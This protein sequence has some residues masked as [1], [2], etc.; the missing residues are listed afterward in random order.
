MDDEIKKPSFLVYYDNEVVVLR[1]PDKEAGKL[2]KSLFPYGREEIKP[3]FE[4]NPALAMA[5]DILSMAIDRDK[6]KYVKRCEKNRENGRKG[7]LAKAGNSKQSLP[8]GKQGLANLADRDMDKDTRFDERRS[9]SGMPLEYVYCTGKSI[10]WGKYVSENIT[11]QK[12]IVNAFVINFEM[13]QRE[14]RGLYF[15][16][17]TKGSGKTMIACVVANEI[18]KTHDISVKFISA[19]DYIELVKAKDDASRGNVKAILEAGLLILDDVGAQVENKDWITTALFRLV[20]RRYTNHYPTI[21]T[22]NVRMEDLKTDSRISDRIYSVSIPVIMPEVNV[23][24][25]IADKHTGEFI[26]NIMQE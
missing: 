7:G 15:Y 13:F 21:F 18:L 24:R 25:Q 5:F 2:F 3:D 4:K 16:S 17:D 23:R 9:R 1:L 10:D 19:T 14:G 6:E 12:N 11:P 22:S 26:K 8:N 20:D